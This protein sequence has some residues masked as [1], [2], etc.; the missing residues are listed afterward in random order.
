MRCSEPLQALKLNPLTLTLLFFLFSAASQAAEVFV[1]SSGKVEGERVYLSDVAKIEGSPVEVEVLKGIVVSESPQP[2]R[3]K[4]LSKREIAGKIAS[5][6]RENK[7]SFKEIRVKGAPFVKVERSCTV[8]GGERIREL[9]GEF[10]KRNYPDVI[11]ISLP[12]PTLRLPVGRFKDEVSL[13]SM[14]RG[15]ARFVYKVYSDGKL[16]KK[17][18]ITARIDRK[19]KVAV[20]KVPIPRG[21]LIRPE[22]VEIRELPSLK[23]RGALSE[24]KDVVGKVAVKDLLVGEP[25]KER[26]LR[27]NFIIK[28]G[29][30]VKVIYDSGAI[31]IELLGVALENGAAGNIIKVKN[32]S[33][34]KILRCRVEKDGSVTFLSE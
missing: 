6:L 33:T 1:K 7:V 30:P 25:I 3:S 17:L 10:L 16:L 20:A 12:S 11:L 14:G 13:D 19:V 21:T 31:H 27:P 18:W 4:T 24:L 26:Y 9:V 28:R 2:C 8:A 23:A 15:Y 5:Y 29:M 32:L 34:G 22:M